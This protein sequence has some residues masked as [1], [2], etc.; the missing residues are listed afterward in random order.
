MHFGLNGLPAPAPHREWPGWA[1]VYRRAVESGCPST[2]KALAVYA[3][4]LAIDWLPGQICA[5]SSVDATTAQ[6]RPERL[7]TA[8]HWLRPL[9]RPPT[10]PSPGTC[11][12]SVRSCCAVGKPSH[13]G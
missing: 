5:G 8:A 6:S 7:T 1:S 2:L 13:P 12:N 4:A 9:K 3:L 10:S 11:C